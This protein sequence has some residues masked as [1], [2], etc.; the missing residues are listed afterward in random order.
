MPAMRREG[1]M[2]RE[3]KGRGDS[4]SCVGAQA[5]AERYFKA[6]VARGNVA[7]A[8]EIVKKAGS[9]LPRE[10]DAVSEADSK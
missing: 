8:L 3:I 6:R 4:A 9:E 5:E 2:K 7:L 1:M 10:G